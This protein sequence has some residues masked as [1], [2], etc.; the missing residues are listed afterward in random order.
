[1]K[2]QSTRQLK[3]CFVLPDT[4][5]RQRVGQLLFSQRGLGVEIRMMH[6]EIVT[7]VLACLIA[8]GTLVA[9]YFASLA[10]FTGMGVIYPMFVAWAAGSTF[11]LS[12]Q[13]RMGWLHVAL[14]GIFVSLTLNLGFEGLRAFYGHPAGVP[15]GPNTNPPPGLTPVPPR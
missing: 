3:L 4:A 12:R 15:G 7:L 9:M 14:V 6:R 8:L 1:L 10:L 11:A 5:S 2:R 13:P